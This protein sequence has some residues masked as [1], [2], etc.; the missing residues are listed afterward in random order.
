MAEEGSRGREP[1]WLGI[2]PRRAVVLSSPYP[3]DE[4]LRRLAAVTTTRTAA[5]WYLDPR[6]AGRPDPLLRGQVGG[7][8]IRVGRWVP[9][10]R[11][12]YYFT[13]AL[14][15]APGGGTALTG[16]IGP[17]RDVGMAVATLT[18]LMFLPGATLLAVGV[19]QLLDGHVIGLVPAALCWFPPA[20]AAGINIMNRRALERDGAALITQLNTI[21]GSTADFP[22][23]AV[24]PGPSGAGASG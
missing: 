12:G 9:V 6:T 2:V 23:P 14:S 11:R 4:C 24:P 13:A 8:W 3:V 21:L 19:I 20:Y 18:R 22:G 1:A 5:S 10:G 16:Q 17:N 7:P 15:A